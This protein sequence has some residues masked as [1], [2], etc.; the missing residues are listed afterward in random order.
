MPDLPICIG[1]YQAMLSQEQTIA[2]PN[3]DY[4]CVGDGEYAIG[5]I[6]Q[7]LRG[8]KTA[9][10]TVCGKNWWMAKSIRLK[11]IRSVISRRC[12]SGLRCISKED[13]FKDVILP[14]LVQRG[15]WCC[16]L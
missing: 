10:Q 5:N 8:S 1:G 2:N 7:H 4:I 9:P 11:R 3:V 6:V 14:F 15:N 16:R 12:L 13:G